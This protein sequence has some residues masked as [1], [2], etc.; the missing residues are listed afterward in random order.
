MLAGRAR[1]GIIS[2]V[3]V[4]KFLVPAAYSQAGRL[5]MLNNTHGSYMI[6]SLP[7]IYSSAI[8]APV[9]GEDR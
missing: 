3:I 6:C 1:R 7:N 5:D 2:T 9:R 8:S 4:F